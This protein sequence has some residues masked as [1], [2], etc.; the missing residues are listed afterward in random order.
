MR[1]PAF[2]EGNRGMGKRLLRQQ[3]AQCQELLLAL[4]KSV[5]LSQ[6]ASIQQ[7]CSAMAVQRKRPIHLE[8]RHLPPPLTGLCVGGN[9]TD[10]IFY[11]EDAPP[12]L[13]EQIILHEVAHVLLGLPE[14]L[15]VLVD[16]WEA[17]MSRA[18]LPPE[19]L[20][21]ARKRECYDQGGECLAEYL[22]TL[23][24]Q[25]WRSL[26]RPESNRA[27]QLQG[28]PDLRWLSEQAGDV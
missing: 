22:G 16:A 2:D 4:E 8:A 25:R 27:P 28:T 6:A 18:T 14:S 19:L 10:Y 13:Q 21:V 23:I 9:A 1:T 12:P 17:S 5:D 26:R 24:E 3:H 15:R 11:A 20:R 7:L